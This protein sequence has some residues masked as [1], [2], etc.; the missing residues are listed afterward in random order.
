MPQ[1][2][3]EPPV[4]NCDVEKCSYNRHHECY[5]PGI[6]VGSDHAI[7]DTF[8]TGQ[9]S[10]DHAGAPVMECSQT[11]CNYNELKNCHAQGIH[12]GSHAQHADCFTYTR[13]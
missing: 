13:E 8:T 9:A 7:C 3:P 1:L 12:V 10:I 6:A 11:D 5:A 2:S 4:S